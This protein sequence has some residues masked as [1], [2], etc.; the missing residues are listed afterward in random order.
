MIALELERVHPVTE[1][2]KLIVATPPKSPNVAA[3]TTA[4]ANVAAGCAGLSTGVVVVLVIVI[5]AL[6]S[7]LGS[8]LAGLL[9]IGG[10][11]IKA[12]AH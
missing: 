7:V 6:V 5:I 8:L 10:V 4:N 2:S 9:D 1:P 3:A 12:V 11:F